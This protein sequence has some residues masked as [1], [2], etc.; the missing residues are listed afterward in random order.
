MQRTL[1]YASRERHSIHVCHIIGLIMVPLLLAPI[2]GIM[3]VCGVQFPTT[4]LGL[5]KAYCEQG[6]AHRSLSEHC[7]HG[8]GMIK[9]IF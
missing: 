8:H 9:I 4:F 7:D 6:M 1:I 2:K 3:S 5:A